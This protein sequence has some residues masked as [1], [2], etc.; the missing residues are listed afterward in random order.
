MLFG[1][2][3]CHFDPKWSRR[4][5]WTQFYFL[6]HENDYRMVRNWCLL[7][8]TPS[9]VQADYLSWLSWFWVSSQ[10]TSCSYSSMCCMRKCVCKLCR[11]CKLCKVSPGFSWFL[12]VS[13]VSMV[14][15][16]Y[17]HCQWQMCRHASGLGHPCS[18][19]NWQKGAIPQE[20]AGD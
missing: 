13:P 2:E 12:L 1:Q 6:G 10:S 5:N 8:S 16:P 18:R 14:F 4:K 17:F 3:F 19:P 7:P 20:A 9:E 15:L 11:L